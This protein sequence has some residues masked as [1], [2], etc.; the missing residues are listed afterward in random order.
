MCY[1]IENCK[2]QSPS[3]SN[4]A[5]VVVR[6]SLVPGAEV[7]E[8]VLEPENQITSPSD[9]LNGIRPSRLTP[10]LIHTSIKLVSI[11]PLI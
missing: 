8:G 4:T 9:S 2:S 10:F 7:V 1:P 5:S 11:Q 3:D 6:V